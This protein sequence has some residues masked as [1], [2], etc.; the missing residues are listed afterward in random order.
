[1]SEWEDIWEPYSMK[2]VSAA[3]EDAQEAARWCRASEIEPRERL[4]RI[5]ELLADINRTLAPRLK[6][7]PTP[8]S[9]QLTQGES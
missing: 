8:A 9:A 5:A 3:R 7:D 6:M 4:I 1:M 2:T